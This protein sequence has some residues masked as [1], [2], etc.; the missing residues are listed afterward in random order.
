MASY[1]TYINRYKDIYYFRKCA[2]G[3]GKETQIVATKKCPDD[4]LKKI[5]RGLEIVES[6]YGKFS[7]RKK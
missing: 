3:R 1:V 4:A 5:P 7:C 2:S 6:P